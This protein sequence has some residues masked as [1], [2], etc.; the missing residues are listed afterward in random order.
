MNKV[1]VCDILS[2][3]DKYCPPW[4]RSAAVSVRHLKVREQAAGLSGSTA[5]QAIR[6]AVP[7]RQ[8]QT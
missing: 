6:R 4:E 3:G 8:G 7:L 2:T 1:I 5:D